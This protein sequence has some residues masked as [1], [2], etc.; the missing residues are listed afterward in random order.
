MVFRRKTPH[1]G[2]VPAIADFWAWWATARGRVQDTIESGRAE[3]LADELH[4]H[5]AAIHPSLQ[6]EFAQ[7]GRS[8]HA[9]VVSAGGD[10]RVR[11]AAARWLAEAP[12][13]DEIWEYHRSRQADPEALAAT[14]EVDG[15]RL[16]LSELRFAFT[17]DSS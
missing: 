11:A 4:T 7:G 13:P 3:T 5:V 1:A 9:L 2:S 8:R 17:V 10:A 15:H 6:W 14:L 12:A 16:D